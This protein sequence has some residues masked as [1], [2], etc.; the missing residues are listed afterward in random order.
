MLETPG[1]RPPRQERSRRTLERVLDA[2][3][4]VFAAHG[5]EGL[6]IAEV[7]RIAKTSP[8]AVYTRFES[9]AVLV[10]AVHDHVLTA[11]SAELDAAFAP[12]SEWDALETAQF[13]ERAVNVLILHL[14]RHAPIVRAIVLRAAVDPVM[15]TSGAPRIRSMADAFTAR[16]LD[17]AADYPHP[18]P[19][20][21]VRDAFGMVFE[22]LSWDIAFGSDYRASGALGAPPDARLP[23]TCRMLLLTSPA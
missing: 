12:H 13:V 22:A 3:A 6:T 23:S 10:R 2:G 7:C 8:G 17:R 5:Y 9:K 21:A 4:D 14:R 1:L 11:L 15:R 18:D 16:M 19:E 20:T